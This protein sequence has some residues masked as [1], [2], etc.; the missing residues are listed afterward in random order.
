M[1]RFQPMF[2]KVLAKP[3]PHEEK[4]G[5][6]Y[7]P[8]SAHRGGPQKAKVLATGKGT[9]TAS[10]GLIPLDVRTGDTVLF[11]QNGGMRIKIDGE[12]LLILLEEEILGTV[13]A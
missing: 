2:N 13:S 12:E 6:I 8:D 9:P 5:H 3:I 11:N 1:R 7:I 10:G 4:I